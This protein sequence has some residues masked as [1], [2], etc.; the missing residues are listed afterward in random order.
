MQNIF[1]EALL[2]TTINLSTPLIIA[3]FAGLIS[4]RSGVINLALEGMM[5][6]GAC[7]AAL[8]SYFTGNPYIGLMA[9]IAIGMLMA[10]AHAYATITWRGDQIISGLALIVAS[11]GGTGF[12]LQLIFK[13]GGNT[14]DVTTLPRI[15]IPFLQ[16]IPI[17]GVLINKQTILVYFAYL[18]PVLMY[19]FLYKTPLG[20]RIR[21]CGED[22]RTADTLGINVYLTR[23]IAV[24]I[25]GALAGLS[26]AYL[27]IVQLSKFQENMSA[28]RGWIA[29]A[30]LILGKWRPW[31]VFLAA[32]FFGFT[33][34][35]QLTMQV[36]FPDSKLP[37]EIFLSL[38]YILTILV[39]AGF[40]GKAIGPAAGGKPY[41]KEQL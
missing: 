16:N 34:A 4:E 18:L 26:G 19:L 41:E 32:L 35:I 17:L 20:M 23:Y 21:A 24:L 3:V 9:S 25:S 12:I 37:R 13:H 7:A 39:L 27:S 5:L 1:S 38:P 40:V 2:A 33:D 15:I 22:P 11:V 8:G 10:L 31:S 14:P 6:A 36:V 29:I 30:A 28:G